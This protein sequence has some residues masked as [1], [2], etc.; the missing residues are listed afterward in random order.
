V[1]D[2][3]T[4]RTLHDVCLCALVRLVAHLVALEAE[5]SVALKRVVGVLATENAVGP[6]AL[7]GTLSR[8]VTELLAVAALY[9]RV[10]LR[11]VPGLPVLHPR[12]HVIIAHVIL[13]SRLLHC[14]PH[15]VVSRHRFLV[16]L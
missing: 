14:E 2:L 16:F 11:V 3:A 12:K 7:V 9:R 15:L 1:S 8:H 4:T 6:A 5:F 10:R 13:F